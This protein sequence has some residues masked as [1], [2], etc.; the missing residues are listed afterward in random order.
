M[1]EQHD[2]NRWKELDPAAPETLERFFELFRYVQAGHC[3]NAVTHDANNYLGAVMAFAELVLL[4]PGIGEDSRKYLQEMIDA[5]KKC[6]HMMNG[7]SGMTHK[8]KAGG[9]IADMAPLIKEALALN[10]Y[11]FKVAG[12]HFESDI[13]EDL[14]TMMVDAANLKLALSALLVNMQEALTDQKDRQARL[15]ARINDP[16]LVLEVWNAGPVIPEAIRD[17]IFEPL[18]TTK[19]GPHLGL[20][21][22]IA[23]RIAENHDGALEYDPERG[24]LLTLPIER[25]LDPP[26]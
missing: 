26:N 16:K 1:T 21:L 22:P 14:P 7:L 9:G 13:H 17:R 15:C 23:R 2:N 19:T 18:F 10:A 6:S 3:I 20:G 24:F 8:R 25:A 4:D 11:D 12:I 5:A